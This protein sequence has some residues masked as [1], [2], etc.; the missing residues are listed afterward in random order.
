MTKIPIINGDMQANKT[1]EEIWSENKD[2][3]IERIYERVVSK[4]GYKCRSIYKTPTKTKS[5]KYR[6]EGN[7]KYWQIYWRGD[8]KYV[9]EVAKELNLTPSSLTGRITKG[10]EIALKQFYNKRKVALPI[11]K[12]GETIWISKSFKYWY[13]HFCKEV[14]KIEPNQ[15]RYEQ[16]LGRNKLYRQKFVKQ[17]IPLEEAERKS[18]KLALKQIPI[19]DLRCK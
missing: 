8:W 16:F 9:S 18:I 10:R 12:N 2:G 5:G 3:E 14:Y 11:E 19:R 4:D 1:E 17:G 15:K 13:Y 6:R 7:G